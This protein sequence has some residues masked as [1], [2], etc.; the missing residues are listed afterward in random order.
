MASKILIVE[1]D[2]DIRD[3]IIDI[4]EDAGF[5]AY[6]AKN[7]NE[8]LD[9]LRNAA[10]L[11]CLI[12]LD[13]MMPGMDGRTFREVQLKMPELSGIPVVLISAFRE[14]EQEAQALRANGFLRKPLKLDEVR[15]AAERFC[16][17]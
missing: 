3:T 16:A 15:Q 8:A 9:K 17:A 10:A 6:G 14:L 12:L 1:D 13:L 4:L 5:N 2:P 7:G 11:P